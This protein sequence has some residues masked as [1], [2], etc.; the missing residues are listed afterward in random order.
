MSIANSRREF[1]GLAAGALAAVSLF[2]KRAMGRLAVDKPALLGGMPVHKGTWPR[3]PEWRQAWEP[4]VLQVLRSGQ[5]Y[6]WRNP[7]ESPPSEIAG[8][9]GVRA[10]PRGARD[11]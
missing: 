6:S 2:P 9:R 4:S 11:G 5:W 7:H 1:F 8:A 3:W 10:T